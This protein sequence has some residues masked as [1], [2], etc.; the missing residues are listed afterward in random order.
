M[1]SEGGRGRERKLTL[2]STFLV[3]MTSEAGARRDDDERATR[4]KEKD[5]KSKAQLLS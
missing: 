1:W 2:F 5:E 4:V 3:R